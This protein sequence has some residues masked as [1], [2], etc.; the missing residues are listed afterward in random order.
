M[1][2]VDEKLRISKQVFANA[3]RGKSLAMYLQ[4]YRA[5]LGCLEEELERFPP[6][7]DVIGSENFMFYPECDLTGRIERIIN[8]IWNMRRLNMAD[9]VR[10]TDT[11]I[12]QRF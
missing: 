6:P 10:G 7:L 8:T 5:Y 2:A 9:V 1:A 3:A 12:H 11:A 4:Q